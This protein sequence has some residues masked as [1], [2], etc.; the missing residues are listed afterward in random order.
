MLGARG[1]FF[2]GA[3]FDDFSPTHHGDAITEI[4]HY[5]HGVRDEE[6]GEAEVALQFFEQVD[7][8]RADADVE[9]GDRLVTD[10]EPGPQDQSAGNADSLALAS[11][12][13]MGVAAESGFVEADG[14]KD[15]N[16][17]LMQISL[18]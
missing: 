10:N 12:K 1:D 17:S 6:I 5:R 8:L 18:V 4:A 9:R 13:F 15:F 14:A 11:G 16:G 2:G 3:D 7:D